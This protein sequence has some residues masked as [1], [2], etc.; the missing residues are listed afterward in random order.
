MSFLTC[1]LV[2][3]VVAATSVCL[4]AWLGVPWPWDGIARIAVVLG[5]VAWIVPAEDISRWH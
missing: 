5:L 2:A 1:F 4:I 3:C